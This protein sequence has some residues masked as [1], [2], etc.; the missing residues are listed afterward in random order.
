VISATPNPAPGGAREPGDNELMRRIQAGSHEA[1][2]QLYDRYADRAYRVARAVTVDALLAEDA[3][4]EGFAAIWKARATYRPEHE[5]AAPWLMTVV[6]HRAIDVNRRNATV[7]SHSAG[8]AS[9]EGHQSRDDVAAEAAERVDSR[10][11][12]T[13]LMRLP[14]AQRE[15]I[16]LAFY[17]ELTHTEIAAQLDVPVGTV[18]G[19]MRLGLHK[20]RGQLDEVSVG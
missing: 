3:V 7:Q 6:R 18:K 12:K 20:I 13:L 8:D 2:A 15:V 14:D 9:L 17:G 1:F 19:R 10:D 5:T 4:Q 11:L 16:V